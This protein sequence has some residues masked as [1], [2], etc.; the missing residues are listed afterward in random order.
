MLCVHVGLIFVVFLDF[1]SSKQHCTSLF[2]LND[3]Y[4]D[5]TDGSD[6]TKSSACSGRLPM[7]SERPFICKGSKISSLSIPASRVGDGICD[8][9][10]GADE[11]GSAW[12]V[13]CENRCND[14]L[15]A[16]RQDAISYYRKIKDGREAKSSMLHHKMLEKKQFDE[17]YKSLKGDRKYL[18]KALLDLSYLYT[19]EHELEVE[20]HF[21]L[22][23]SRLHL[24]ATGLEEECDLWRGTEPQALPGSLDIHETILR[25]SNES[26]MEQSIRDR[27]RTAKCYYSTMKDE[28]KKNHMNIGAYVGFMKSGGGKALSNRR[29]STSTYMRKKGLFGRYLEF[30]ETG[31]IRFWMTLSEWLGF[32]ISPLT[33][34]YKG[35]DHVIKSTFS[36]LLVNAKEHISLNE[37]ADQNSFSLRLS[38]FWIKFVNKKTGVPKIFDYESNGFI[39]NTLGYIQPYLVTPF[40]VLHIASESPQLYYN[41]YFNPLEKRRLQQR[42]QACMIREGMRIA[43][44]ELNVVQQRIKDIEEKKA[45][46]GRRRFEG[47]LYIDEDNDWGSDGL[48]EKLKGYDMHYSTGSYLYKVSMFED[49]YQ[50]DIHLGKFTN[51]GTEEIKQRGNEKRRKMNL[52]MTMKVTIVTQ[53]YSTLDHG[54]GLLDRLGFDVKEISES[55]KWLWQ[56]FT[57]NAKK[58]TH[59][60]D[61]Q[62]Y[63]GGDWCHNAGRR[64]EVV[65]R[66]SC[67]PYNKI[68]DIV[69]T[70]LCSYDL[71]L[72]TPLTCTQAMEMEARH[73]LEDLEVFGYVRK[74]KNSNGRKE[75]TIDDADM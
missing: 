17:E 7:R 13:D 36:Y 35:C 18:K 2:A 27:L 23:R 56:F 10:D 29:R 58:Q 70:E 60:Y 12:G 51:W 1:V 9:C 28:T 49:I 21:K 19:D 15:L 39:M 65:V 32:I 34:V 22:L 14:E 71:K 37:N 45:R 69:E 72:E 64:R 40:W 44:L 74:D 50:D 54:S 11:E 48:W 38:K 68:V 63:G 55:V 3:D 16:T 61:A 75:S 53:I 46:D 33:F 59:S 66:L 8:C 25:P 43:R 62:F 5:C 30:E 4:C 57:S 41:Y 26:Y 6:E 42:N 24:C 52:W 31:Y 20:A 67:G 47:D 73:R